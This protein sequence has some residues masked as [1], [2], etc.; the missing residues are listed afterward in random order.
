MSRCALCQFNLMVCQYSFPFSTSADAPV[1]REE[2][3]L[4]DPRT[5]ANLDGPCELVYSQLG[6]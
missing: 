2:A 1:V 3:H 5:G 6:E 4:F